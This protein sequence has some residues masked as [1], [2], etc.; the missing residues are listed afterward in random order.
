MFQTTDTIKRICR[1][2]NKNK[3]GMTLI[4]VLCSIFVL[5]IVFAGVVS[6]VVFSQSMVYTD[7]ARDKASD[8]AQLVADELLTVAKGCDG[9]IASTR[10]AIEAYLLSSGE[11]IEYKVDSSAFGYSGAAD[12]EIQYTLVECKDTDTDDTT[13]VSGNTVPAVTAT[14]QGVTI[15]VRV[16]YQKVNGGGAYDCV[17]VSAF[18]PTAYVNT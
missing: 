17:E 7:N 6:A 13:T 9:T 2:F 14:E 8:Q 4:E 12:E 16:Y 1:R 18:A 3:K 10:S 11:D 15:I 5:A